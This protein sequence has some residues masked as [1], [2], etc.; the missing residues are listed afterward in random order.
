[1]RKILAISLLI[2]L[3]MGINLYA[4]E[5]QTINTSEILKNIREKEKA[6]NIRE[7][8]L[9]AKEARLNAMEQDLLARENDI[10]K[11]RDEVSK[12]LKILGEKQ[13]KE[14]DNL[15][16]V[17]SKAKP[18]AAA[19]IIREMDMGTALAIFNKM[20]PNVAGKIL[21]ELGKTDPEFASKMAEKLTYQPKF[22]DDKK[23]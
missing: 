21:N 9:N 19:N 1:M 17:Y 22:G 12:E 20:T 4:Q 18:K 11:I 3:C 8:D 13:D 7:A 16:N 15:V 2:A 23:K 10:K 6:L 14:L 5:N